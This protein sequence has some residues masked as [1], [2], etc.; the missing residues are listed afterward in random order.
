MMRRPLRLAGLLA[1]LA[2]PV[3]GSAVRTA[4]ALQPSPTLTVS[5][6]YGG[7]NVTVEEYFPN[8]IRIAEGTTVSFTQRSLREHT[9]TFLAGQPKPEPDIPQ[10]EDSSTRM[11][12]PLAE[13][14]TLPNGPYDGSTFINSGLMDQGERFTVTF[15]KA[16][17]YEYVCLPRGHDSMLGTVEVVPAGT[18]GLTTQEQIDRA[19]AAEWPTFD[20]EVREM[21]ELRGR[22][23]SLDNADGTKT[24][25]VRNG[26]DFRDEES[27]VRVSLRA[28]LPN[29]LSIKKGD[30]VVW[31]TDTRVPVHTVTFPPQDQ[32]PAS[33]WSP[34]T[35]D[36]ELVA[37][38]LLGSTGR[39]RG[40]PS[41]LGW[42]RIIE[43]PTINRYVR[44]SAIYDPTRLFSS[45]PLGDGPAPT[46]G[47][48]FSL[49]F[50]TPGTFF[51]FCVPHVEIG[52]IGQIT[53][54]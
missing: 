10:P 54:E 35:E 1:V 7:A 31:H 36:G 25:F 28:F 38:E 40:D 50:D 44:P 18:A 5:V 45:G 26:T 16:G 21:W 53:V 42:P 20:A 12:N 51:Y 48:A 19:T 30:T 14:P 23:A 24:W 22:P 49:T 9:V 32:P 33:R 34:R 17:V 2:I 15:S 11:K 39:Y 4:S 41:S 29:Q 46:I 6:G 52:Q 13:F 3:I 43:D 27:R 37:L 47:R 8:K